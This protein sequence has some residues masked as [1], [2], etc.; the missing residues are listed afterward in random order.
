MVYCFRF[1]AIVSGLFPAYPRVY[2]SRDWTNDTF[3]LNDDFKDTEDLDGVF[4]GLH[5]EHSAY[6][7]GTW[8][9]KL[10]KKGELREF[11]NEPS[12]KTAAPSKGASGHHNEQHI[13]PDGQEGQGLLPHGH[14]SQIERDESMLDPHC[15][16]QILKRHYAPWCLWHAGG[17]SSFLRVSPRLS[18]PGGVAGQTCSI[19]V[20]VNQRLNRCLQS[21]SPRE[22]ATPVVL[23]RS[24]SLLRG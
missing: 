19:V 12:S 20:W 11:T 2:F 10:T 1:P 15:V 5:N 3:N 22:Q 8:Q 6:D 4:S 23:P 13:M 17:I 14:P 18:R 16:L 21:R 24:S 7:T 9:Y